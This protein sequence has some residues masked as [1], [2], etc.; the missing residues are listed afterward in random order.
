MPRVMRSRARATRSPERGSV[1][2]PPT[3]G[4]PWDSPS[5]PCFL[6]AGPTH[7]SRPVVRAKVLGDS[8]HPAHPGQ[9]TDS[10]M[11]RPPT[12]S[13]SCSVAPVTVPVPW[14]SGPEPGKGGFA[15]GSPAPPAHVLCPPEVA[16]A[17]WPA[18]VPMD[19]GPGSRQVCG[20]KPLPADACSPVTGRDGCATG[21][22]RRHSV[23]R[24]ATQG[25]A[26]R[27][28]VRGSG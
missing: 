23:G 12:P 22:V 6:R 15:V 24:K 18:H 9:T 17:A 13:S 3:G 5:S 10:G 28:A 11:T 2:L 20:G 21:W 19:K 26:V 4:Q 8:K 7:P 27:E 14:G 16:A 25:G 1:S